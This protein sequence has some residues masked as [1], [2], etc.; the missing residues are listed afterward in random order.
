MAFSMN[1]AEVARASG[2]PVGCQS[3]TVLWD[4]LLGRGSFGEVYEGV[5]Y[6][7]EVACAVKTSKLPGAEPESFVASSGAVVSSPRSSC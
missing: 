1:L 7:G 4:K 2:G 5:A 3:V 6:P